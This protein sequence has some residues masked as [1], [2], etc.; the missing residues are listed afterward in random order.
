[1]HDFTVAM[2][3][4]SLTICVRVSACGLRRSNN[5][6]RTI[7][8]CWSVVQSAM[9]YSPNI[10]KQLR[11]G[12]CKRMGLLP[13]YA[14]AACIKGVREELIHAELQTKACWTQT[15]THMAELCTGT[16]QALPVAA[17]TAPALFIKC[18]NLQDSSM[19]MLCSSRRR[20]KVLSNRP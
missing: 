13:T 6:Q 2:I 8:W 3:L 1:M 10:H 11:D 18:L 20:L 9:V 17:V 16:C 14:T 5:M 15:Q 19:Y 7:C 4:M 12:S